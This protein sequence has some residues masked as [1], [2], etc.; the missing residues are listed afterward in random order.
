MPSPHAVGTCSP[1]TVSKSLTWHILLVL[2]H[3]TGPYIQG[4]P[5]PPELKS[6]RSQPLD[7][8]Q[9]QPSLEWSPIPSTQLQDIPTSDP[10]PRSSAST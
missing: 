9:G 4:G 1:Q 10:A 6:P 5:S 2:L 7:I 3:P 8:Y